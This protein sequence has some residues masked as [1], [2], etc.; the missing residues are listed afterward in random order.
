MRKLIIE[1]FYAWNTLRMMRAYCN[2]MNRNVGDCSRFRMTPSKELVRKYNINPT[3]FNVWAL[4]EE[5]FNRLENEF[6]T[7]D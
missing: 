5:N 3:D 6:K 1:I 4:L 2:Y 7:V